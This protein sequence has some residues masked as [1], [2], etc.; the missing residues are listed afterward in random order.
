MMGL[1][2]A[3]D[4]LELIGGTL[5]LV[6]AQLDNPA[7]FAHLLQARIPESW[8]PA[9]INTAVMKFT[10]AQLARGAA[11]AGWWCWYFVQRETPASNRALLGMGGFKGQPA[12]DGTVEVG[13]SILASF[14]NRGYATEAVE[15]LVYWAFAHPQVTRVIAETL[16]HLRPSIRV[17]EKA[18][19][20]PVEPGPQKESISFELLRAA[21]LSR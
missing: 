13:Y 16:P 4:R 1:T 8:P 21:Y 9:F 18:G 3:T 17:L 10:A 12:P 11:E 14:Q 2:V 6:Q 5:E 20:A 15:G 7:H 19:F